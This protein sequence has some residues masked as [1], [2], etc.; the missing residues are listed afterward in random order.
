[1]ILRT[2]VDLI[3]TS[4]VADAIERQSIGQHIHANQCHDGDQRDPLASNV[5]VHVIFSCC[6]IAHPVAESNSRC[7]V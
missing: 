7:V 1:M 2:G 3:E 5:S 6:S 4:R